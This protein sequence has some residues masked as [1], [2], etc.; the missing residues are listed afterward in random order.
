MSKFLVGYDI[1]KKNSYAKLYRALGGFENC[2][3][4][5]QS[6]YLVS[7]YSTEAELTAK[8]R[9]ALSPKDSLLIIKVK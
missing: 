7:T 3:Y 9:T 4:V 2:Q 5:Q 8:I 1:R 6:L